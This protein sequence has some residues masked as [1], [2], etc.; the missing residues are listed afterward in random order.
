M[1]DLSRQQ[2]ADQNRGI[3][4]AKTSFDNPAQRKY[5]ATRL[6]QTVIQEVSETKF[7]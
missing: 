1:C 7:G 3:T 5:S 6:D 2:I 4:I